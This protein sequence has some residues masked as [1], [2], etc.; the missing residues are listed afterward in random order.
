M[1]AELHFPHQMYS[2]SQTLTWAQPGQ[3]PHSFFADLKATSWTHTRYE[4]ILPVLVNRDKVHFVVEYSRRN[5]VDAVISLHRNLWIV[6]RMD[7]RW[8]IA[9]RSY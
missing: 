1:D 3:H 9:L 4:S 7:A 6:T 2:G 8:G 5:A